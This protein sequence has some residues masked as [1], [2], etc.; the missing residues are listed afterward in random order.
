MKKLLLMLALFCV[1]VVISSGCVV[2]SPI[3]MYK[4]YSVRDNP[5]R[6]PVKAGIAKVKLA[7]ETSVASIVTFSLPIPFMTTTAVFP[8]DTEEGFL[9]D[10]L[11]QYIRDVKLFDFA[12]S[13]PFDKR[14]VDVI[15]NF[16]FERFTA[17]NNKLYSEGLLLFNFLVPYI[18]PQLSI[19]GII[20]PF[21]LPQEI[22]SANIEL[23]LDVNLPD[24][25][26]VTSYQSS[27]YGTE[28]VWIYGQPY[29]NYTWYNSV[30][31]KVF[32]RALD[33]IKGQ[34][35]GDSDHIVNAVEKYRKKQR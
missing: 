18:V 33:D 13:S 6:L 30:F 3:L 22:F 28:A 17:S 24:G 31:R 5:N 21:A 15:L 16:T 4:Q 14:D 7:Q 12:Y 34:L 8:K 27:H 10:S 26:K 25:T 35:E 1:A 29:A 20:N 11:L 2:R 19:L 23:H 32:L 9:E